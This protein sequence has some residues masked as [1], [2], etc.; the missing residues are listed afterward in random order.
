MDSIILN[1]IKM[2][3]VDHGRGPTVLLVH[4][5]PLDHGMWHGQVAVLSRQFRVLAPDLRGLGRSGADGTDVVSMEQLADDLA[6]LLDA[7]GSSS[8]WFFAGCRW[9]AMSDGRFGG[10]IAHGCGA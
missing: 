6:A 3:Y 4:G 7:R 1:G 10:S 9:G 2:R 8:R 5:F